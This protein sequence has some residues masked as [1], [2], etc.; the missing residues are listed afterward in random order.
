MDSAP[1]DSD[2]ATEN[3]EVQKLHV[4]C[5]WNVRQLLEALRPGQDCKPW[6][7]TEVVEKG[8]GA[9]AKGSTVNY[10]SERAGLPIKILG[11]TGAR[12][13]GDKGPVWVWLHEP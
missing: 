7:I 5:N 6:A 12:K 13:E 3:A 9:W 1:W 8:S 10:Q 11:W 4:D 2:E